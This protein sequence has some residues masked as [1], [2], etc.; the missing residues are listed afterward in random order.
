MS[1]TLLLRRVL[2]VNAVA[3]AAVSALFFVA[4]PPLAR[5]FRIDAALLWVLGAVLLA[6]AGHVAYVARKPVI[7]RGEALYF[8]VVDAAYVVATAVILLGWPQL[9]SGYGR[10][11]FALIADVVAVFS[12]LE[13]LSYRRMTSPLAQPA[14]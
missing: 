5:L 13:Y 11:F 12:L 3:T 8:A 6:F 1:P 2:T 10:L 4:G 14:A 9:L 7:S